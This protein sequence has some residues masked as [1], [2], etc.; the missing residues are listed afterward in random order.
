MLTPSKNTVPEKDD[1][2]KKRRFSFSRAFSELRNR[3]DIPL[4]LEGK[5]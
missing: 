3:D 2:I 1:E 5:K 4:L